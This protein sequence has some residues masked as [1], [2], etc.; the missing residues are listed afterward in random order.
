MLL[1]H[2][3]VLV[4]L[5]VLRFN[6]PFN[7]FSVMSERSHRILGI[8]QYLRELMCFAQG[9]ITVNLWGSNIGPL[10]SESDAPRLASPLTILILVSYYKSTNNSLCEIFPFN[11]RVPSNMP[12]CINY[13]QKHHE[14]T[15]TAKRWTFL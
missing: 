10:D 8:I 2:I 9:H 7:Y 6:V 4:C 5:F 11:L 1:P 12:A 13:K 14:E 15:I 3:I